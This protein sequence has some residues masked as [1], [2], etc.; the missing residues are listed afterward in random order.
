MDHGRKLLSHYG[1]VCGPEAVEM[2]LPLP[3]SFEDGPEAAYQRAS[4]AIGY[5]LSAAKGQEITLIRYTLTR[6][7]EVTKSRLYGHVAF[8][9]TGIIGAWLST[10][11]P[12]APGVVPLDDDSFGKGF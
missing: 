12:I 3:D 5:D 8:Y 10:D 9:K 1:W 7:S 4:K 6:R 2:S 11:G